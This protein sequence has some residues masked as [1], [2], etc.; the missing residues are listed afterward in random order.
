MEEPDRHD[1]WHDGWQG[2]QRDDWRP[3]RHY[4]RAQRI[5]ARVQRWQGRWSGEPLRRDP[6]DR[7][8][9]GVAAGVARWRGF[10]PTTVRIAFVIATLFS[11]GTAIPFYFVAWL[12]IPAGEKGAEPAGDCSSI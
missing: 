11:Q 2:G 5:A 9:A 1:G 8:A 7:L 6:G 10:N 4:E 3:D 12:L